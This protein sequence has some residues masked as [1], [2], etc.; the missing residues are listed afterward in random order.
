MGRGDERRRHFP[1]GF[2]ALAPAA[3]VAAAAAAAAAFLS[4]RGVC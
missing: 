3:A 4:S 1:P 2:K